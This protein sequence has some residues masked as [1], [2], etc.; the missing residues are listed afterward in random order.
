L[1]VYASGRLVRTMAFAG[2]NPGKGSTVSPA[3]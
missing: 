1:S 2:L 3:W